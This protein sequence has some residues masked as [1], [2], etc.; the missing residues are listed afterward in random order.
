MPDAS[1][2]F[3]FMNIPASPREN[4]RVQQIQCQLRRRPLSLDDSV[5]CRNRFAV[6]EL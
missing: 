6:A 4:A 3:L 1:L 2:P 5:L